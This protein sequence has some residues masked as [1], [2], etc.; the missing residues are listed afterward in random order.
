MINANISF[1]CSLFNNVICGNIRESNTGTESIT[2]Q[3]VVNIVN[4]RNLNKHDLPVTKNRIISSIKHFNYHRY[5]IK[6]IVHHGSLY[7]YYMF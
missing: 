2:I 1:Q 5:K 4:R 6:I 7:Y 3:R